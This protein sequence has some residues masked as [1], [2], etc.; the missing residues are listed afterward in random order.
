MACK[1]IT[2]IYGAVQSI[3]RGADHMYSPPLTLSTA[4]VM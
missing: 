4:P 2:Q 1:S 3:G